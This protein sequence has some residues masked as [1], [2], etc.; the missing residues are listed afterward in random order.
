MRRDGI[1]A[2]SQVTGFSDIGR[3]GRILGVSYSFTVN[4]TSFRGEGAVPEQ[5]ERSVREST[6]LTIRYLPA[7]PRV[8][9]PVGWE[10]Y[11]DYWAWFFLMLPML[12]VYVG[13]MMLRSGHKERRLLAEGLPA[14]A[15]ITRSYLFGR[16]GHYWEYESRTRDADIHSGSIP[17]DD[18]Q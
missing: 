2:T 15:T 6:T 12:P 8:N 18:S 7:N 11:P 13:I 5:L 9:Y 17:F 16:S 4:G 3:Y 1:E 14:I 10:E